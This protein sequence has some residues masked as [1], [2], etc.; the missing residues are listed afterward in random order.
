MPKLKPFT[1]KGW[2]GICPVYIHNYES[3]ED[4]V[5]VAE[6]HWSMLPLGLISVIGYW[7]VN[8]YR[9]W[10]GKPETVGYSLWGVSELDV[11]IIMDTYE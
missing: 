1:H 7:A 5:I 2:F 3:D 9:D 11:P 8:S 10:S 6:R 4:A